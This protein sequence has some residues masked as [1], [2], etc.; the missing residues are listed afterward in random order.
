MN[1]PTKTNKFSLFP[2]T[3]ILLELA[4]WRLGLRTMKGVSPSVWHV[5]C[6]LAIGPSLVYWLPKQSQ[7]G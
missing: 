5:I 2:L 6:L 4:Q 7:N 1:Y 3:R